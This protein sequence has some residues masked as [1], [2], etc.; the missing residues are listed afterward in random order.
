MIRLLPQAKVDKSLLCCKKNLVTKD[1]NRDAVVTGFLQPW[2]LN[3][4]DDKR[5]KV[6]DNPVD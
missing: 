2:F 6:D 4:A 3:H 5:Y 1:G